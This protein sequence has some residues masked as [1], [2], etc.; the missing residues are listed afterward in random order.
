[1]IKN[2]AGQLLPAASYQIIT[3]ACQAHHGSALEAFNQAVNR[4]REEYMECVN[5]WGDEQPDFHLCLSVARR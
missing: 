4:L 5:G 3:P 1:M 2:K